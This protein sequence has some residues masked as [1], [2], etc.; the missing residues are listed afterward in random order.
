MSFDSPLDGAVEV[1]LLGPTR[2]AATLQDLGVTPHLV[3]VSTCYVAGNRRGSAPEIM[4]TDDPFSVDIDWR[5]EVEGARRARSDAEAQ[6]RS[7]EKLVEF[8]A[9]ARHELGAAGTPA[10]VV[11]D[12]AAAR[13]AGW[14]TAWSRPASPGPPRSAGPTPTPTRRRSAS[15]RCSRRTATCR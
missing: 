9:A 10:L 11:Q 3:A 1:N 15:G 7:P 5:R 4:V 8:R 6:S 14:A 13:R 12:R 2:I